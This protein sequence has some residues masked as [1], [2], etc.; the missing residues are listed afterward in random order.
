MDTMFTRRR[1]VISAA[2]LAA[3]VTAGTSLVRVASAQ[4]TD[5]P[6]LLVTAIDYA[7]EMPSTFEGGFSRITM[8]N[9]GMMDHHV[10]FFKMNDGVTHE[11]VLEVFG[12][13]DF[14]A[15]MQ[16]VSVYGGV[17]C[18]PGHTSS[19]IAFL[20]PGDYLAI[21]MIPD[22]DG[23]PHFVHGMY[24]PVTITDVT[25][26]LE[27]PATDGTISLVDMTFEGLPTELAA[28]PHTW[29][30]TNNGP[31]LHEIVLL[32]LVP[33]L[34]LDQLMQMMEGGPGGEASAS[35]AADHDAGH[36]ASP[37]AAASPAGG[38]PFQVVGGTAPM[39]VGAVNYLEMDLDPAT[40]VAIC[41]VPDAA[42]GMPHFMMGM[43]SEFTVA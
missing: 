9:Q 19:V 35:P 20:D 6:E 38:P 2:T 7:F 40:Y 30:V 34:N 42:T 11:E 25:S 41:F 14:G 37:A 28:G 21:C 1:V 16:M 31:Q 39:G 17:G 27:A 10:I 4:D 3:A 33:G 32:Q 26:T 36:E 22:P 12:G 15:V 13:G 23:V 43:A 29:D 24:M 8:V 18:G 5:Y